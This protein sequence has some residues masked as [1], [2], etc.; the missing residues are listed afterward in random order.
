MILEV[1]RSDISVTEIAFSFEGGRRFSFILPWPKGESGEGGS[2]QTAG[3]SEASGDC[4][5]RV[6]QWS[7]GDWVASAGVCFHM[8]G[9]MTSWEYQPCTQL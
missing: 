9:K 3:R 2:V 5:P 7:S 8:D 6:S 4:D 1:H